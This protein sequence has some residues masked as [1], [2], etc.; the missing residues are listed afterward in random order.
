MNIIK[1]ISK[2]M[3]ELGMKLRQANMAYSA[4]EFIKKTLQ[5]ALTMSFGMLFIIFMFVAP[6]VSKIMLV[7]I[8]AIS[9]PVA[10]LFLFFYFFQMPT[11]R[12][13]KL[14]RQIDREVIFAGRF[15]VVELESGVPLFDAIKNIS[16]NFKYVGAYFQEIVEKVSVGTNLEDAITEAVEQVPSESLNKIFWQ[17]SNSISTGSDV[18]RPIN[19][20]IETLIREQQIAVSEYGRKLNPLAMF[21]MLI[22]VVSPSL[23]ITL[24]TILSIFMGFK[25]SL[26]LLLTIAGL[27][28][29]IQFMFVAMISS[30]RPAVEF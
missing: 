24:V 29:F 15:L 22:A 7:K 5:T 26:P 18:I 21:Y 10:F 28:G 6:Y 11:V 1:L 20:V 16:K 13:G 2:S 25:L 23:G 14:C 12:I 17:I 3:P 8:L 9:F 4:E 30:S 19:N 27:L